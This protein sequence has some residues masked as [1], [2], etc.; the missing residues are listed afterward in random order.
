MC[1]RDR[2]SR[3]VRNR[4]C[5]YPLSASLTEDRETIESYQ[6]LS[7]ALVS[8]SVH[9]FV[10]E[11]SLPNAVSHLQSFALTS[12]VLS[13]GAVSL[14]NDTLFIISF[15]RMLNFTEEY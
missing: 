9:M 10:L 15:S 12:S 14:V 4:Q 5:R 2:L 11:I 13:F 7:D 6:R 3:G 8:I 1:I